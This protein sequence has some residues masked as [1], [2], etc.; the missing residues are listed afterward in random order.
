MIAT[1]RTQSET[2][3]PMTATVGKLEEFRC[4]TRT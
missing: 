2:G 3:A 4:E 1:E